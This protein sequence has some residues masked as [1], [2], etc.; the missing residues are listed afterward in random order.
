MT[1]VTVTIPRVREQIAGAAQACGRDPQAVHLVAVSKRH[2]ASM[3]REALAAG[4][5]HFGENYVAEALEKIA[6]IDSPE[7][8]WH[9][10]G[11][12][13]GNKTR[14]VAAHFQWV[15][16]VDR[17][18]I[19]RRLSAQRPDNLPALNVCLQMSLEDDPRRGGAQT[20]DLAALADL[21]DSL[22]GLRLRG[23]MGMPPAGLSADEL[24]T[25]FR[26]VASMLAT[27]NEARGTLD[28][29]SMGMSG[30]LEIAIAE[31]A[32]HVRVGTAIF[33]QR[34]PLAL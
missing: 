34:E 10:I 1:D 27:L 5:R 24:H 30:D 28:V 23:L 9:F 4:Q 2:P 31:G 15:H 8:I 16:T 29:L 11:Q 12:L 3:V 19:A 26:S 32:T 17:A 21:V 18:R 14:D 13:Q 25:A 20:S 7:A 33:G 6:A 22:P